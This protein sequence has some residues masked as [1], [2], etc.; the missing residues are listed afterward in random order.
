MDMKALGVVS[1]AFCWKVTID[2]LVVA[3]EGGLLDTISLAIYVALARAKVPRANAL[4]ADGGEPDFELATDEETF[5]LCVDRVP[6][7]ITVAKGRDAQLLIDANEVEA[8]TAESSICV[9]VNRQQ[10]ICSVDQAGGSFAWAQLSSAIAL[11][12][13]I[14]TG[15][16]HGLDESINHDQAAETE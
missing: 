3:E 2:I 11:A 7:I 13:T 14:S 12:E 4:V 10:Q 16:F 8:S 6:I 5:K 15:V 1:G 9:A